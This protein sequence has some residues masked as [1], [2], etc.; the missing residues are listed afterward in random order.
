MFR[1]TNVYIVCT[2]NVQAQSCRPKCQL[3]NE[4][5][6][7]FPWPE[8][9]EVPGSENSEIHKFYLTAWQKLKW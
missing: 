9:S 3:K 7:E 1:D 5:F 4:N 8:A 6:L 2:M